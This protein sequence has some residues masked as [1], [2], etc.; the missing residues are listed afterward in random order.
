M[1]IRKYKISHVAHSYAL[2]Y[3]YT[4]QLWS[5]SSTLPNW[6][7]VASTFL[8]PFLPTSLSPSLP[9]LLSI[10]YAQVLS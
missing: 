6:T 7:F 2:H 8:L 3:I 1:A 4:R 10:F 9:S 5:R